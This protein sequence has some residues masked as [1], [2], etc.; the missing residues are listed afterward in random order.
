MNLHSLDFLSSILGETGAT[1]NIVTDDAS[2]LQN[3]QDIVSTILEVYYKLSKCNS[4][5]NSLLQQDW[6]AESFL[7]TD[8]N[9]EPST[10][11]ATAVLLAP[12]IPDLQVSKLVPE[13]DESKCSNKKRRK[14][15]NF[16]TEELEQ[17]QSKMKQPRTKYRRNESKPYDSMVQQFKY[18]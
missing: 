1:D 8:C 6:S 17:M 12:S 14:D 10:S 13:N 9:V 18:K 7:I 2:L 5:D 15:S 3:S 4:S 16:S 11:I